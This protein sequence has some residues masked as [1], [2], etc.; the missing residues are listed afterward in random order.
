MIGLAAMTLAIYILPALFLNGISADSVGY[1]VAGENFWKGRGYTIELKG[2]V[3]SDISIG[4]SNATLFPMGYSLVAGFLFAK[5]DSSHSVQVL[6]V[7]FT[8]ANVAIIYRSTLLIARRAIALLTGILVAWLPL[9]AHHSYQVMSEQLSLLLTLLALWCVVAQP[10]SRWGWVLSGLWGGLAY[11][12]RT[13][14]VV[15]LPALFIASIMN[16]DRAIRDRTLEAVCVLAGWIIGVGPVTL[17]QLGEPSGIL[18]PYFSVFLRA[19]DLN[20]LLRLAQPAPWAATPFQLLSEQ[21]PAVVHRVLSNGGRYL[22]FLISSHGLSVIASGLPLAVAGLLTR[23]KFGM[24]VL[25]VAAILYFVIA[26]AYWFV[27]LERYLLVPIVLFLPLSL[28]ALDACWAP[29]SQVLGKRTSLVALSLAAVILAHPRIMLV[30]RLNVDAVQAFV[31][32]SARVSISDGEWLSTANWLK[33]HGPPKRIV[34]VPV[35]YLDVFHWHTRIPAVILPKAQTGRQLFDFLH[36][37]HATYV[38]L[39]QSPE[40]LAGPERR[41]YADSFAPET[42]GPVLREGNLRLYTV[43]QRWTSNP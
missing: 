2:Y 12:V 41:V 21:F 17:I 7:I 25:G 28:A 24:R 10:S 9:M 14:N 26:S 31:N 20:D 19:L 5:T 8:A 32:G 27:F 6:N 15:L 42:N 13:A 4:G 16:K 29:M 35:A 18:P 3:L 11:T 1:L 36:E 34:A 22:T 37:N 23:E 43:P 33:R 30:A 39:T 40:D 38:L